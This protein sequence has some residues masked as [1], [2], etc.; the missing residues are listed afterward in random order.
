MFYGHGCSDT[1]GEPRA[2]LEPLAAGCVN[3]GCRS[4]PASSDPSTM[5]T[6]A[7]AE[8]KLSSLPVLKLIAEST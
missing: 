2:Q 6:L 7:D 8:S 1:D 4:R 5:T 3:R